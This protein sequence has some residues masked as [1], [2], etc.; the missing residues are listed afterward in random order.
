MSMQSP[1]RLFADRSLADT[2]AYIPLLYPF[3]GLQM[4]ETT[5]YLALAYS[6]HGWDASCF[7]M[8]ENPEGAEY[9]VVPH[10]YWW[11]KA[12]RPDL[13]QKYCAISKKYNVPLLVDAMSDSYGSVNLHNARVLRTHQYRSFLPAYEVTTPYAVEDLLESYCGGRVSFR[14][15]AHT[16]SVGFAGFSSLPLKARM[17]TYAKEIPVR[18]KSLWDT[19][20]VPHTRGVFWRKAAMDIFGRSPDVRCDFLS[21]SSYSGHA[22][23]VVGDMHQ[24][25]KEFI[26]NLLNNDYALVVRGDPNASQRLYEVLSIGRIPVIIDT[27]CVFPLEDRIKYGE[28]CVIIPHAQ[29]SSAPDILCEFHR[30]IPEEKFRAMQMQARNVYEQYLRIDS[31]SKYLVSM[32]RQPVNV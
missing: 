11:M 4:K 6:K 17:R 15:K 30:N 20:Y 18:L 10:E 9:I 8:L 23:T 31:F 29:L 12:K 14:N 5:P 27:D 3:W 25:R 13:L 7:E 2:W 24:N 26:D 1:L 28:F 16:P 22:K 21:R 32:L 19:R